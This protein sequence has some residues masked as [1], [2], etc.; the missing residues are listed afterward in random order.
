MP[1]LTPEQ[2]Y[3]LAT[4]VAGLNVVLFMFLA[5]FGPVSYPSS[6]FTFM[7]WTLPIVYIADSLLLIVLNLSAP[8]IQWPLLI[9]TV[10]FLLFTL[11]MI[12]A[13]RL[14]FEDKK[15]IELEN[16]KRI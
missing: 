4:L 9:I 5:M 6:F 14:E 1:E 12:S 13:M 8:A 15:R 16:R 10:L 11:F 3:N 7:I 2:L